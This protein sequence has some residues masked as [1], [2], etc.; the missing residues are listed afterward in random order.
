MECNVYF[1]MILLV[2]KYIKIK[3]WYFKKLY[4]FIYWVIKKNYIKL[5]FF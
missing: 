3:N 2:K 1:Y 4:I 5:K